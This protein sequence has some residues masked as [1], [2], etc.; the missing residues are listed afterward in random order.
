[1]SIVR[2]GGAG[3]GDLNQTG[4]YILFPADEATFVDILAT[5]GG[6]QATAINNKLAAEF[7][8]LEQQAMGTPGYQIDV[9]FPMTIDADKPTSSL[10]TGSYVQ[11]GGVRIIG[12]LAEDATSPIGRVEV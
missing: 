1:G 5:S 2:T 7:L 8:T 6:S 12:G 11:A 10:T 4:N 9:P 3:L